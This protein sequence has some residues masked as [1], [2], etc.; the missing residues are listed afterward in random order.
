VNP[1]LADYGRESLAEVLP[2]IGAHLGLGQAEDVLDLPQADKYLLLLV[3]GLGWRQLRDYPGAPTL[4]A[5][6]LRLRAGAPSTTATS[7]ASLGTGLPP[8]QHGIAGYSFRYPRQQ[9]LTVLR[10]PRQVNGLDVQPRLTYF[11]RMRAAGVQTHALLPSKFAASGLTAAALRGHSFSGLP[12]DAPVAK[13]VELALDSVSGPGRVFSYV[14]ERDLDHAGHAFGVGSQ[15]WMAALSRAEALVT[16]LRMRLPKDVVLLATGDHG[17][18]NIPSGSRIVWEEHAELRAG[19]DQIAG[20]PRFRH[21]Y[22]AEPLAVAARWQQALGDRAWTLTRAQAFAAGWFGPVDE[23][24]RGRFGDVVV[25]MRDDN[26]LLSA[27]LPKEHRLVGMHGSLSAAEV[28]VPLLA[29]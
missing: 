8:G 28:E 12:T 14:Y 5:A 4:A 23:H 1:C 29:V 13:V 22:T 18:V 10:W 26:A 27:S 9:I 16:Q 7:L 20:E 11:E 24:L 21:I 3:D 25:A 15:P 17:M 19:V 6:Q 2:S